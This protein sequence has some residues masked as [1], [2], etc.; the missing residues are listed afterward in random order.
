MSLIY[1]LG[2]TIF[3]SFLLVLVI[4]L[5]L[6]NYRHSS[7]PVSTRSQPAS[8]HYLIPIASGLLL[9]C[10]GVYLAVRP[11]APSATNLVASGDSSEESFYSSVNV[12]F[13]IAYSITGSSL[14]IVLLI[15]VAM[16]NYGKFC[17]D[18][19]ESVRSA[20]RQMQP[21]EQA[22]ILKVAALQITSVNLTKRWLT[23]FLNLIIGLLIKVYSSKTGIGVIF[24]LIS[25][26]TVGP[27]IQELVI[28]IFHLFK[29]NQLQSQ[30]AEV[31]EMISRVLLLNGL[32]RDIE[33]LQRLVHGLANQKGFLIVIDTDRLL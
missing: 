27:L 29:L 8:K 15:I 4:G 14:I 32:N 17:Y 31:Q 24:I 7:A 22:K 19:V 23:T 33:K 6:A 2:Y 11:D 25:F 26:I 16:F 21:D 30:Q 1:E 13:N 20:R 28:D 5:V 10:L 18:K 3:I 9:L 12:I